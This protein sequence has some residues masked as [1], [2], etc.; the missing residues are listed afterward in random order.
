MAMVEQ[1][2]SGMLTVEQAARE[3]GLKESTIRAWLLRRKISFVKLGR[4]VRISREEV[5]R[6]IKENTIPA[7]PDYGR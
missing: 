3:L 5:N 4:C 6:L 1:V 2:A 7:R